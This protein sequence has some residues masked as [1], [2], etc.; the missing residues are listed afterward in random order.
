MARKKATYGR[1]FLLQSLLEV[2]AQ[3]L[4]H[5]PEPFQYG[6]LLQIAKLT[7][8]EERPVTDR[9]RLIL[10]VKLIFIDHWNHSN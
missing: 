4:K 5:C 3:Y 10:N 2:G 8:I 6:V 1:F 9:T 7:C